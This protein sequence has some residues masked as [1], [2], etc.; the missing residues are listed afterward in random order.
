M[1]ATDDILRSY[2]APRAVMRGLLARGRSEPWAL[3]ILLAALAVI[4]VAQWPRLSRIAHLDPDQPL[5]GLMLGT[6]LAALAALPAFYLLAGASHVIARA[7]FGGRGSFYGARLAL[8]WALLAASPLMLLQGL[9]AGFIGAGAQLTFVSA[10]VGV[11]FA[12]IWLAA[13]RVAEFEHPGG[14]A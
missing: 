11:V 12:A 2:R 9:V 3:S 1:S 13:L 10:A 6:G 14:G 5:T 7:F 8:F 4:F